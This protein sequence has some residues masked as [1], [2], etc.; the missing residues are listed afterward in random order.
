MGR[1]AWLA[2]GAGA[3][4]ALLFIGS[5]LALFAG[6]ISYRKECLE[7]DGISISRSWT[8]TWFAPIPYLFRPSEDGCVVHTGTR[9]ALDALGVA[10][11]QPT[12]ASLIATKYAKS[13]TN[14]NAAYLGQVKVILSKYLADSETSR[15]FSEGISILAEA[16]T[17]LRRLSP[18]RRS[19]SLHARLLSALGTTQRH[20]E[21]A[22]AA[23][24]KGDKAT[25]TRTAQQIRSDGVR[26]QALVA[27]FNR[28]VAAL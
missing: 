14:D 16:Q 5:Q 20:G 3:L 26:L 13:T 18:P 12:T 11:Y 21:L 24:Q 15:G 10:K 4:L 8:F 22:Q 6:G 1:L 19:E 17:S 25:Y 23:V 2:E 9:V 28:E 27:E 7:Q